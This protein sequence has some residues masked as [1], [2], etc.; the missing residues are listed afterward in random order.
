MVLFR[1]AVKQICRRHGYH[2]T[3]MSRPN[4]ANSVSSGWHLH[5][6]LVDRAGE[7]A[8]RPGRDEY[9]PLSET[10]R[11]YL[12]GLL[13]HAVT[14]FPTSG[15]SVGIEPSRLTRKILP[16]GL[17]RQ[18]PKKFVGVYRGRGGLLEL[19]PVSPSPM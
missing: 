9:H 14:I 11:S 12:A 7:N 2:A 4:F 19:F 16:F 3:F 15:L 17:V 1:S 10:G 6:S 5:Q 8:F 13:P 18:V